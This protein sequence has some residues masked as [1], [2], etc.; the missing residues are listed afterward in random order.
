MA[1]NTTIGILRGRAYYIAR[2]A[3]F[4]MFATLPLHFIFQRWRASDIIAGL[5]FVLLVA[6]A[7][8]SVVARRY[9]ALGWAVLAMLLHC[10]SA[11]A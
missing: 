11:F 4:A 1:S 3:M 6:V 10:M 7:T 9:W 8:L 2:G 5:A